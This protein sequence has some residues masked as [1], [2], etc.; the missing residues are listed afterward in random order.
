ML[1]TVLAFFLG[2]S[3]LFSNSN[4]CAE[5]PVEIEYSS[6][7]SWVKP[8]DYLYKD[9]SLNNE[10]SV[11]YL[12]SD[13][14]YDI[15][16]KDMSVFSHI[17][18]QPINENGL[19]H[20]A[21]LSISFNPG[22]QKL[23]WHSITVTRKGKVSNRLAKKKIKILNEDDSLDNRQYDGRV[24]ALAILEDI[25]VNDVINYSY[26][27]TG[28]NPI[29]GEKRFGRFATSWGLTV[30]NVHL[31]LLT[32]EDA[33]VQ[34]SDNDNKYTKV[35]ENGLTEYTWNIENTKAVSQEDR[36]PSWFTPFSYIDF[37]EYRNWLEVNQWA[38]DLYS[39]KSLSKSL[40]NKISDWKKQ[41]STPQQQISAALQFIQD[42]VRYFGIEIG[43]NTH[44]PFTPAEVFERRYGDCKDKT[45]L[46]IAILDKLGVTAYPAL[47]S[48]YAGKILTKQLPSPGAFDHVIVNMNYQ[49]TNYWLD[50]TMSHQ[51]GGIN[52]IG[53]IDY[54]NALVIKKDNKNLTRI[55][56]PENRNPTIET[57]EIFDLADLDKPSILSVE[58]IY[59]AL[60]ADFLRY[61]LASNG[62]K[63]LSEN[64]L[65]FYSRTFPEIESLEEIKVEDNYEKNEIT[66]F[67]KYKIDNWTVREAGKRYV[68]VYAAD[69]RDYLVAP[70]TLIRQ[71][72]F[73]VINNIDLIYK[74]TIKVQNNKVLNFEMSDLSLNNQY[75]DYE[76]KTNSKG[77]LISVT[78]KF[79]PKTSFVEGINTS[80]YVS[81]IKNL[82]EQLGL[83]IILFD[84][85]GEPIKKQDRKLRSL[86]KRLLKKK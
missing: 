82:K 19:E 40:L 47:V 24:K 31:R 54:K 30:E 52:K 38:I 27:I 34:F 45:T 46:L 65:N 44:R 78:H 41:Y 22:F 26:T 66:V 32:T 28:T 25:R 4:I 67:T 13:Q 64:F 37:S 62:R 10:S 60:K 43:Q 18:M 73:S 80:D 12:L 42:E 15:S 81:E 55:E 72:P 83:S 68:S 63:A 84:K 71:H 8:F 6:P 51:R 9:L 2:L 57:I 17:S 86:A 79:K 23:N 70:S 77:N 5:T 61:S 39:N 33:Y 56:R 7:P 48:S 49:N 53:F 36:Y 50:G 1:R 58:T 14:Q 76:K 16:S 69:I 59:S 74:Q 11:R 21:E 85:T 29:L 35:T 20:V 75:F 3:I